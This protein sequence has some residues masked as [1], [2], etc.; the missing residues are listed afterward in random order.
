MGFDVEPFRAAVHEG[1]WKLVWKVALPSRVELFNLAQD[2]SEETNLAAQNLPIVA[3]LKQR[4]EALSQE[5][6]PSLF[7]T[8]A[9]GAA[10][11]VLFTSVATPEDAE[12]IENQP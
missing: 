1:D 6:T 4:I 3:R 10:K 11:S 7:L 12:A 9:L 2:P 5:A 8:E